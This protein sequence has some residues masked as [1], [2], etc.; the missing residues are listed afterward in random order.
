M[1]D[2]RSFIA[3]LEQSGEL[4][5]ISRPV[6][7]KSELPALIKQLEQRG[8]AY[9]F[10]A[11]EGADVPLVG[12][13]LNGPKRLGQAIGKDVS[14]TYTHRD[15]AAAFGQAFAN[16]LPHT[17]VEKAPVKEVILTGADIDLDK[18]PVPTFFELD[19][20]PFIT[21]AV[22]ISRDPEHGQLNMGFYR[23][24]GFKVCD[25]E[26]VLALRD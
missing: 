21:G 12:G 17:V 18:L 8:L 1:H 19:S 24:L 3:E 25:D 11:I 14:G 6:K 16:P 5:R 9:I 13:L 26:Q 4:V 2:L 23:S 22:G 15:H 7:R 20:G 10:E